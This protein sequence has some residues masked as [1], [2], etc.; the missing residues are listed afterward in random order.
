VALENLWVLTTIKKASAQNKKALRMVEM[1]K[2]HATLAT[3]HHIG[4]QEH[5]ITFP[6]VLQDRRNFFGK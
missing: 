6:A 2:G 5:F 1:Q 3:L 4:P